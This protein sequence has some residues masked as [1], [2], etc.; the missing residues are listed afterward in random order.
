MRRLVLATVLL[1]SACTAGPAPSEVVPK[2]A[3]VPIPANVS[4]VT[5]A[6]TT[7]AGPAPEC[8]A[9][10][11]LRPGPLPPAGQMPEGSAMDRILKRGRLI[12]GVDQNTFLFGFRNPTSGAS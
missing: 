12:A 4:T 2:P 1:V 9:T 6:P 3:P 8:N 10:A 7:S 11:S 5:N